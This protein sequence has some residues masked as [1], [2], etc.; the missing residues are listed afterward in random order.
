MLY[1]YGYYSR[2]GSLAFIRLL[3]QK[4]KKYWYS[5]QEK[6][7][8]GCWIYVNDYKASEKR[9]YNQVKPNLP[10]HATW[11][12]S[13]AFKRV[14][15][16]VSYNINSLCQ[17]NHSEKIF[18]KSEK[19][20][21]LLVMIRIM[22]IISW[23]AWWRSWN[24][25]LFYFILFYLFYCYS[26]TIV[27]VFPPLLSPAPLTNC[28]HRN[29]HIF[30]ILFE[31]NVLNLKIHLVRRLCKDC[32]SYFGGLPSTFPIKSHYFSSIL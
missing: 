13:C 28:S 6:S 15:R 9:P 19:T 3:T 4:F 7:K 24:S 30:K 5:R 22:L 26:I 17:I 20:I 2:E 25:L 23:E 16:W 10:H 11:S 12:Y 31:K 1:L 14:P 27:P 18:L 29:T 21:V 8:L 32:G